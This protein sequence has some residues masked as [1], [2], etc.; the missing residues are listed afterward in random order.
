MMR[1]SLSRV[2]WRSSP[3]VSVFAPYFVRVS[4]A[5][6]S[7]YVT[8]DRGLTVSTHYIDG[9]DRLDSEIITKF[10]KTFDYPSPLTVVRDYG[11]PGEMGDRQAL[12]LALSDLAVHA[13][14]A[15]SVSG[16][17]R[18]F[19]DGYA[20]EASVLMMQHSGGIYDAETFKRE[21]LDENVRVVGASGKEG[22]SFLFIPFSELER[23][24][25]ALTGA[26][27]A[28]KVRVYS[29]LATGTAVFE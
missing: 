10:R 13:G 18:E 20:S 27:G 7:Y 16:A 2:R 17:L 9:F 1:L 5:G 19:Y 11:F 8:L 24:V 4:H 3:V 21:S 12:A 26:S 23:V 29:V 28:S 6:R 22:V 15:R 14:L 25:C